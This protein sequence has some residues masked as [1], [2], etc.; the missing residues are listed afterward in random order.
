MRDNGLSRLI[1]EGIS[2]SNATALKRTTFVAEDLIM[3]ERKPTFT[4]FDD[5]QDDE[6]SLAV[7]SV[8]R[9]ILNAS[10][11]NWGTSPEWPRFRSLIM[12]LFGREG[13]ESKLKRTDHKDGG[14]NDGP[15]SASRRSDSA[16]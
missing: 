1:L 10:Q 11:S 7:K 12:F 6:L 16:K 4:D 14:K 13:L 9:Q 15:A 5:A 3:T 8:R 2:M